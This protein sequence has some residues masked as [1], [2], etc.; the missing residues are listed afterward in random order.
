MHHGGH[1]SITGQKKSTKDDSPEMRTILLQKCFSP[2]DA[3][4]LG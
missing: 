2:P 3:R 4:T 1:G